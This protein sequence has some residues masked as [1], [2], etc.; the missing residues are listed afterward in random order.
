MLQIGTRKFMNYGFENLELLQLERPNT[1]EIQDERGFIGSDGWVGFAASE[2][3]MNCLEE[4]AGRVKLVVTEG[5]LV[6][7]DDLKHPQVKEILE[8]LSRPRP[9]SEKFYGLRGAGI[10]TIR[11]VFSSRG[12][13]L[14]Y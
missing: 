7:E 12:G 4:G 13:N 9:Q 1:I 14:T 5:R 11:K 3:A 8:N 6:V 10:S 2:L